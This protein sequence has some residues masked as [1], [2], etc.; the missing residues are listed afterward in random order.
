MF[1]DTLYRAIVQHALKVRGQIDVAQ[2]GGH[3][4]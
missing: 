4:R 2:M 3:A 1:L